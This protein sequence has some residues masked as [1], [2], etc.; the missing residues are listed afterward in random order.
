[1]KVISNIK[2]TKVS[3]IYNLQL[4][5]IL[6]ISLFRC[7]SRSTTSMNRSPNLKSANR[8]T[9]IMN[10]SPSIKSINRKI[11]RIRIR[12][13]I[14]TAPKYEQASYEDNVVNKRNRL[15]SPY[16]N[17][18]DEK[19][20]QR[21][22]TYS[23]DT[24]DYSYDWR[25][26]WSNTNYSKPGL[27][28]SNSYLKSHTKD[29]YDTNYNTKIPNDFLLNSYKMRNPLV[30][31]LSISKYNNQNIPN[32]PTVIE[33]EK[34]L[35]DI[36]QS[37]YGY[38][39]ITLCK[40]HNYQRTHKQFYKLLIQIK[41]DI[42][43]N[44]LDDDEDN[45]DGLIFIYNGHGDIDGAILSDGKRMSMTQ[46]ISMLDNNRLEYWK[47]EPRIIF[48]LSTNIE[49][50][51]DS[52]LD[53]H[54]GVH[55]HNMKQSQG[56][57]NFNKETVNEQ[58]YKVTKCKSLDHSEN[59]VSTYDK[60][61]YSIEKG[62]TVIYTNTYAKSSTDNSTDNK[63][64][65]KG[66]AFVETL[67][68]LFGYNISEYNLEEILRMIGKKLSK[69]TKSQESIEWKSNFFQSLYLERKIN[70][71]HTNIMPFDNI[72]SLNLNTLEIVEENSVSYNN[73]DELDT[74]NKREEEDEKY[75][76]E[77]VMEKSIDSLSMLYNIMDKKNSIS[78]LS[79]REV[80]QQISKTHLSSGSELDQIKRIAY[81]VKHSK[82]LIKQLY[83]IIELSK[84]DKNKSLEAANAFTIL[85][86]SDEVFDHKD[87]KGIIVATNID[88]VWK[89]P[90]LSKNSFIKADF[91]G[92]DLRGA[93][94]SNSNFQGAN[95]TEANLKDT[96]LGICKKTLEG[97]SGVISSVSYSKDGKF[98]V[99][100][101]YDNTI[102]IW[103][104]LTGEELITLEGHDSYVT[105]VS[106][107]PD[108]K[109]IVS[110]S[111]DKTIKIWNV[112]SGKEIQTLQGHDDDVNS[113]KYSPDGK[114]IISGSYDKTIKI[115][116]AQSGE[117]TQTLK[118]H[119]SS[120]MS[121]NYSKDS[122]FIVSGSYDTTIRIWHCQSGEEIK[123]L[124]GHL[125][126]V[127]SVNFSKDNKFIAS[128]SYDKTIKIWDVKSGKEVQTM[129]GHT[130]DVN[131]IDYSP[132]G[133]YIV[134]GSY[135]KNI[136]IWNIQTGKE[137][138]TLEGHTS[139]IRSV[140]Y[141]PDDKHIVTGSEDNTI[142]IW[143]APTVG[144][145]N[146]SM[147]HTSYVISV[148]FSPDGKYVASGSYDNTI[149]IWNCITGKVIHTL[150]G[151]KRYVMS[152]CFSPDSKYMVSGSDDCTIKVWDVKTGNQIHSMR[153]HNRS[154]MSV[155]YSNDG[156][157][158]VSG[159][160]DNNIKIWNADSGKESLTL[161]GHEGSVNS[162]NFSPDD[163]FVVSG[164]S[165]STIKIWDILLEESILSLDEHT[166]DINSVNY[167]S[168]GKYIVS[169][170]DDNTIK[171]WDISAGKEIHS[172]EED[173]GSIMSVN[174]SNDGKFIVCGSSDNTIKI[175]D[176]STGKEL[177]ILEGHTRCVMSV[178]FSKDGKY[179]VSGSDDG[180]VKIWRV[181]DQKMIH[182]LG[183]P[184]CYQG[185]DFRDAIGI[186]EVH[187]EE[188]KLAGAIISDDESDYESDE[189]IEYEDEDEDEDEDE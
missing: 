97:H 168:D 187:K 130:D 135:D 99:S 92:A 81:T 36:F 64:K 26:R 121:I 120:V 127:N 167:S 34:L 132:D 189:E 153:G 45:Y 91:S 43:D 109:F 170:S 9:P 125:G 63:S 138:Q 8:K 166:G 100:G 185:A 174:F 184:Q 13:S 151:H 28:I 27:V 11:N 122:N 66:S 71:K 165:D 48:N 114:Y 53:R 150:R 101:S 40:D 146:L 37:N 161:G 134:S 39:V 2:Q 30:T 82:E 181:S 80:L 104:S 154:V 157:C 126:L 3:I 88:G 44:Y 163:K 116:D 144:S 142:K 139:Y 102:K 74:I 113:V 159:S 119:I 86:F 107:S 55:H 85:N 24:V 1:M 22:R 21:T 76:E 147:G 70:R 129:R 61:W 68:E 65:T 156:K 72:P 98:I 128:G 94:M 54:T 78:K 117:E 160:E 42:E 16:S 47:D 32:L 108:G 84:K 62:F 179:I 141:S 19:E 155:N 87:F 10:L 29:I 188:L 164:S 105:S 50:V 178:N 7:S 23:E 31:I 73:G 115:W 176:A 59:I 4:I 83:E 93:R 118:G 77:T 182:S 6:I 137:I 149:K 18:K 20:N 96:Y 38:S 33:D 17:I 57:R 52:F 14:A 58:N 143:D 158:I 172:L 56:L 106:F 25:K 175:L 51:K 35:S 69:V 41:R 46:I 177:H 123:I 171:I 112:E 103:Y 131:S 75:H 5:F 110:G 169:G 145:F 152:V 67:Y 162:V 15:N 111:E 124:K 95:F 183:N 12:Q 186:Y 79:T 173:S 60:L 89:G 49:T 148:N 180:T 136:K 140:N 90:D 133:K